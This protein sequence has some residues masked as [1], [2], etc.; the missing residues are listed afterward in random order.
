MVKAQYFSEHTAL[1]GGT[2]VR[3]VDRSASSSC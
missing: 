3:D 1:Y 2:H